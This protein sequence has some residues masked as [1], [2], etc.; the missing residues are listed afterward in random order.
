M[1][2]K[3][4]IALV[5]VDGVMIS[6]F[7]LIVRLLL[8]VLFGSLTGYERERARKP[9]GLRTHILV[10]LGSC[11]FAILSFDAFPGSDPSRIAAYVVA[12]IGFI[13]AGTII[14][15]RDR[16]LGITTAS[17]LWVTAAV[18]LAVGVGYYL[19]ALLTTVIAFLTL[20]LVG[21]I[22]KS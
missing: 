3:S 2:L 14:Q 13:G 16:V 6:E 17:A 10:C 7:N 1:A 4:Y 18:G 5:L 8:A 22:E 20:S 9:A 12:G 15:E 19:A 21:R 11:L